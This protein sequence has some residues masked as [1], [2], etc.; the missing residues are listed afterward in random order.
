ML[1]D[2]DSTDRHGIQIIDKRLFQIAGNMLLANKTLDM[3]MALFTSPHTF[4]GTPADSTQSDNEIMRLIGNARS[5]HNICV[6]ARNRA[7]MSDYGLLAHLLNNVSDAQLA[8]YL[9]VIDEVRKSH[10]RCPICTLKIISFCE[11]YSQERLP[12][13]HQ[14]YFR[15]Y[16]KWYKKLGRERNFRKEVHEAVLFAQ[17]VPVIFPT[18]V[19]FF[20]GDTDEF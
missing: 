14:K 7:G 11:Y 13:A 12:S 16:E 20:R 10:F 19:R 5:V 2:A 15:L 17:P 6:M 8:S 1:D 3:K 9:N 4:D 18:N